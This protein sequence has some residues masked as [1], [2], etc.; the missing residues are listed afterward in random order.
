MTFNKPHW[1]RLQRWLIEPIDTT[2]KFTY[3]RARILATFLLI[4][5][6]VALLLYITLWLAHAPGDNPSHDAFL[7]ILPFTIVGLAAA[8]SLSR[9]RFLTAAIWLALLVISLSIYTRA[10]LFQDVRDV[11]ILVFLIE[12]LIVAHIFLSKRGT[13]VFIVAQL[14]AISA[15]PF[16]FPDIQTTDLIVWSVS[17]IG[18][19]AVIL[20]LPPQLVR[21]GQ[22]KR[23]A[24]LR[25]MAQRYQWLVAFSPN[26]IAVH[27]DGILLEINPEGLHLLGTDDE[28]QVIGKPVAQFLE[29]NEAGSLSARLLRMHS[30]NDFALRT[31]EKL[32]RLDGTKLNVIM[33]AIP[34]LFEGKLATQVI[35]HEAARRPKTATDEQGLIELLSDYSY[36]MRI[37]DDGTYHLAWIRGNFEAVTGYSTA[38][39]TT[40]ADLLQIVHPDD[41]PMM[42]QHVQTAA[43]GRTKVSELRLLT[44]AGDTL[45]IRDY[46]QPVWDTRQQI[47]T[48]IHSVVQNVTNYFHT[49][50][51][52]QT[53]ALQQAVVA[54]LGQRALI[55]QPDAQNLL[56]EAITLMAQVLDVE[57]GRL[58]EISEDRKRLTYKAGIGW[59]VTPAALSLEMGEQNSQAAYTLAINEP[60]ILSDAATEQRFQLSDTLK[61]HGVVSGVSVVVHGQDQAL[62]VLEIYTGT[63]RKFSLDDVNFVQSIANVVAAFTEFQRTQ[64]A[65]KEQR[66]FA[67]ALREVAAA[68]NSTLE[69]DEV[70]DRMLKHL[71]RVLPHDAASIMLAEGD[72]A[73]VIRHSGYEKYGVTEAALRSFDLPIKKSPILDE[74]TRTG[75]PYPI[76]DVRQHKDW[77]TVKGNE[78]I[79]SYVGAPI[80]FEDEVLGI[81]NVDSATPGLFTETHAQ[82]LQTFANQASI[83]IR[84]ARHAKELEAR[85]N[86]RTAELDIERSRLQTILD[87]TGEGIFYVEGITIQYANEELVAMTGYT[88]P[89]LEGQSAAIFID[90]TLIADPTAFW[91]EIQETL[92]RSA[93]WR[94]ETRFVRKNGST[95]DA[96]LTVSLARLVDENEPPRAVIVVRDISR[97]K[98]LEAQKSRFIANAAHELRNPIAAL[99]TRIWMIWRDPD[100]APQ[101]IEILSRIIDRMNR[102]VEDLL[103]LSRFE[104][105][106]IN[107]RRRD[108]ILQTLLSEV[109]TVQEAEAAQKQ[110]RLTW[111]LPPDPLRVFVDPDRVYQVITNLVTNAINYTPEQGAVR[112]F[113]T[114]QATA[115]THMVNVYVQ[116][117]GIGIEP[118]HL[119]HVFQPFYRV[120]DKVKGTGLGLSIA[121][122]IIR[123]HGGVITVE[124]EVGHGSTFCVSLPLLPEITE[125]ADDTPT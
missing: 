22:E 90:K 52:L 102:L 44:P 30:S 80:M 125:P 60:V 100:H 46:S 79:R 19:T 119:P 64:L 55:P 72:A 20:I 118:E 59:R 114:T 57:F 116:D 120:T 34:V 92:P 69:L 78:W 53:H 43:A 115:G 99:N 27:R 85:V 36:G 112:I 39:V 110:I 13:M 96:A 56:E 26:L 14:I 7:R 74:M 8:Y 108:V 16:I 33:T 40:Y 4:L 91:N 37:E 94:S 122:E 24:A 77:I 124:S 32:I 50:M 82:R 2:D 63:P 28:T 117:D 81:I 65:E 75:L 17:V 84:N 98:A 109:G 113:V 21:Q 76:D 54:E 107:L 89:E 42:Q 66:L 88:R 71:S 123:L 35:I 51:S 101:H 47:V 73:R 106:V 31:A 58:L 45:W 104:H 68:I 23:E 49:E 12:P 6:S 10:L 111:D 87:A 86:Q 97:A 103:D 3:Q 29:T 11:R 95:F 70:L 93:T 62:G 9:T 1:R 41:R 15:L 18:F 61:Q 105:G 121:Q 38:T 5:V 83:A 48:G 67:E 25:E